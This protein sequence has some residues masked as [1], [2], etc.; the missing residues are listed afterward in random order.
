MANVYS[1][2][3]PLHG[4]GP[5]T[6]QF[7]ELS[8]FAYNQASRRSSILAVLVSTAEQQRSRWGAA[9]TASLLSKHAFVFCCPHVSL[10]ATQ[11]LLQRM[12]A[13]LFQERP[14][15]TVTY[16]MQWLEAE[17]K[18]REEKQRVATSE[19]GGA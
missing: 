1:S 16:L 2:T 17:K 3:R 12:C 11:D 18:R 10:Q 14:A 9:A 15:D 19:A 6:T 13:D 7:E 5:Q 8:E 4:S